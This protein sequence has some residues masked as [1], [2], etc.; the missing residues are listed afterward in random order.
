LRIRRWPAIKARFLQPRG[1]TVDAE[2]DQLI[3]DTLNSVLREIAH[4]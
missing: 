3:A 2:G 1:L 4:S